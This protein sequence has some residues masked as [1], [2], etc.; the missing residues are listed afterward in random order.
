MIQNLG[1]NRILWLSVALLS[2]IAALVGV[3]KPDVYN[4]VISMEL[5]P[6]VLAQDL[7]TIIASIVV[8]FLTVRIKEEDSI[9]QMVILG[10]V[11]YLFYGYGIYVI[12]RFY[13]VLYF[14]Y[15]AIFGLSFY[16]TIYSVANIRKEILPNIQLLKTIRFVSVGFLLIN[17]LIYYPLWISQLL[18]LV[19]SGQKIEFLYSIYIL[20][21][22]IIFPLMI[23]VAMMAAK[24]EGLGLLL[25]PVLFIKGFT[26]LFS[27][28][29]GGILNLL[30]HQQVDVGGIWLFLGLSMVFLILSVVYFRNL[31]L[32]GENGLM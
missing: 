31:K 27:V 14:V 2:L 4:Q 9:K 21:C 5:L 15:M 25:T 13:N 10:I 29:L 8:L 3:A 19:L 17:P 24:N 32:N 23:I 26:L 12:E 18:P 30:Y 6:G 7:M 20:D 16:S 22:C 11:I 1:K 28:A